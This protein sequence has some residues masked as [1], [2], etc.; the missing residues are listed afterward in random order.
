MTFNDYK[1]TKI[2]FTDANFACGT[3]SYSVVDVDTGLELTWFSINTIDAATG[4]Y[5]L[6]LSPRGIA[7]NTDL[8]LKLVLT[9]TNDPAK[10]AED[11][12]TVTIDV[13]CVITTLTAPT[14]P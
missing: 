11:T 5:E 12:F 6:V 4:S 10:T 9:S 14:S 8:N 13:D 7:D 1:D 2:A 3:S